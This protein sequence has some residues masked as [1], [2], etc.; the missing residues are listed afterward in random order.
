MTLVKSLDNMIE[1]YAVGKLQIAKDR[2]YNKIEQGGIGLLKLSKLDIAMKSTWVNRW[3]REGHLVDITGSQVISTARNESIEY[4]NKDP[5]SLARHP[6]ARGI[7]NAWHE[8]RNKVYEND[9]NVFSAGIFS[10]LGIRNRM[11]EMLGGG[12]IFGRGRY[13]LIQEQ[14]WDIPLGV[15]CVEE[16]I[17]EKWEIQNIMGINLTNLEYGKLRGSIK[18]VHSKFKP[19]WEMR[20]KGKNITEWLAPIKKGAMK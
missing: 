18:Y 17:R 10:N 13:E 2:I 1:K 3:K 7:A 19:L 8:F 12:N 20:G 4:T 6:C 15:F 5:I 9:G 16:G 11:G 14:I